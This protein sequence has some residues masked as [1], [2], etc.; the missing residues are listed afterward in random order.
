MGRAGDS[1]TS[2]KSL[3]RIYEVEA[4]PEGIYSVGETDCR[5]GVE[6]AGCK[7]LLTKHAADGSLVW[8]LRTEVGDTATFN[9]GVA[10]AE[11]GVYVVGTAII[12]DPRFGPGNWKDVR[13]SAFVQKYTHDGV[14]VWR[15][16]DWF[17]GPPGYRIKTSSGCSIAVDDSGI[18]TITGHWLSKGCRGFLR[19]LSFGGELV[20]LGG[21]GSA[22]A[23]GDGRVF[24]EYGT[25]SVDGEFL[26]TRT[27]PGQ[28]INVREQGLAYH[29]G[30]LYFCSTDRFSGRSQGPAQ[31]DVYKTDLEG[32]VAWH[33]EY[34]R[35]S[36]WAGPTVGPMSRQTCAIEADSNGVLL[37]T[38]LA[39]RHKSYSPG[40]AVRRWTLAGTE[41]ASWDFPSLADPLP[42]SV[43]VLG[44]AVYVSGH[45]ATAN[46]GFTA[47]LSGDALLAPA[48]VLLADARQIAVLD[49]HYGAGPVSATVRQ[50]DGSGDH[51]RVAFSDDL[52]PIDFFVVRDLDG[53]GAADLGVL[54]HEP[55]VVEI[56][57]SATGRPVS[58]I[59]LDTDFEPVAAV[60]AAAAAPTIAVLMLHRARTYLRVEEFDARSGASL[61][62]VAFNPAFEPIDLLALGSGESRRYAVLQ[63]SPG[64]GQAGKLEIRDTRGS[65]AVNAWL[66]RAMEPQEALVYTDPGGAERIAVLRRNAELGW[67]DIAIVDAG[68]AARLQ[69]LAFNA[70]YVA[71][72]FV[73]SADID[74]NLAPQFSL[75][76]RRGADGKV[77]METRDLGADALLHNVFL[78]PDQP[79]QDLVYLGPGSGAATPSVG[80]LVRDEGDFSLIVVDLLTGQK[81][82]ALDFAP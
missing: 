39:Y 53:N 61:R 41:T 67:Q 63:A 79:V 73:H 2:F 54:S 31:V 72:A 38:N 70:Q 65:P 29:D 62:T 11:S 13:E 12:D 36:R 59:P 23:V 25:Y 19:K 34:P 69:A 49:H 80:L 71:T 17:D 66:G 9:H 43:S 26:G 48:A 46:S 33:V 81:T 30:A 75:A 28:P 78:T 4:A 82:G 60:T 55:A 51:L 76:G 1:Y 40:L 77:K 58:T 35:S 45:D 21:Y 14:E 27:G 15:Y 64:P 37:A 56:V 7:G 32:N 3:P 22:L 5:E 57:D 50:V 47:R 6:Y 52:R 42:L 44:D 68:A 8:R 74:A 18:Y 16:V 10:V 24:T 20:W